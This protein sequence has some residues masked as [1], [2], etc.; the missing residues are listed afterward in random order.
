MVI[1]V[2]AVIMCF[3]GTGHKSIKVEGSC[4]TEKC[5]CEDKEFER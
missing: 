1:L 2:P 4:C 5:T 3:I